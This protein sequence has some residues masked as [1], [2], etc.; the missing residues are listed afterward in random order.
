MNKTRW[1]VAW[2]VLAAILAVLLN[3]A[4]GDKTIITANGGIA[5]ISNGAVL[6][7]PAPGY[8]GP[9]SFSYTVSDGQGGAA[10]ATVN[11]I[12]VPE[13]PAAPT[14]NAGPDQTVRAPWWGWFGARVTLDGSGS[15]GGLP[16]VGYVWS[17]G[18]DP[19]DAVQAVVYLR[20]GKYTFTLTVEDTDGRVS[21]PD[22]VI[23]TVK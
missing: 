9:D 18:P 4:F 8:L 21:G 20:R 1:Y 6:Y 19:R 10:T 11:I 22:T 16:L 14:A 23:V 12:V 13:A 15:G 3:A 17:G 5:T 2:A 7:T